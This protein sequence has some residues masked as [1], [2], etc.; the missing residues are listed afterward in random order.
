MNAL[1]V[2]IVIV[3]TQLKAAVHKSAVASLEKNVDAP[4]NVVKRS[5]IAL[6][7]TAVTVLFMPIVSAPKNVVT[8]LKEDVALERPEENV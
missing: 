5:R 7:R 3:V 6:L 8:K 4:D 2:T 1:K